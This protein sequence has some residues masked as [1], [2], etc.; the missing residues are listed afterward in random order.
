MAVVARK[1]LA[2]Q[3]LTL[4]YGQTPHVRISKLRRSLIYK[5]T[6]LLFERILAVAQMRHNS[7]LIIHP[8]RDTVGLR[9]VLLVN[10]VA[11]FVPRRRIPLFWQIIV[12][13]ATTNFDYEVIRLLEEI[14]WLVTELVFFVA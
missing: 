11:L 9:Q 2:F 7:V 13:I 6:T 14:L 12:S 1:D 4:R 5:V 3:G 10:F 8:F